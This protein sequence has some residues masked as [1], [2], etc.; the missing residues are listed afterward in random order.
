MENAKLGFSRL[1]FHFVFFSRNVPL[2]S[3]AKRV[4][5]TL[6]ELLVVIAIIAILIALLV[7]AVQKVRDAAAL[8]QCI[9][10]VKQI[11]LATH[12]YEKAEK[13]LPGC[14]TPT[15]SVATAMSRG[16]PCSP[17]CCRTSISRHCTTRASAANPIVGPSG[18]GWILS[19]RLRRVAIVN[20]YNCPAD[21]SNPTHLDQSG[22]FGY[23]NSTLGSQPV[24][25]FSPYATTNSRANLMVYDPNLNRSINNS[26]PD[27]SSNTIMIGHCLQLCDAT[28]NPSWGKLMSTGVPILAT[29][30]RS[31]PSRFLAGPDV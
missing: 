25:T 7:P 18:F 20:V 11:G 2:S 10:N 19:Q 4:G 13:V 23:S 27:G 29:R 30:A 5:F 21:G 28:L 12:N 22:S 17:T 6:I 9:N 1:R 15:G 24:G 14:G 31:I 26:M 3:T 16:V 8:T